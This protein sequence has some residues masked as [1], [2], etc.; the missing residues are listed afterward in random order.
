ME[1]LITNDDG[2]G[3]KGIMTLVRLM[4]TFG[5]VTVVAPGT[6]QSGKSNAITFDH[7]LLH[8]I[9]RTDKHVVYTTNGTP[10]DCVK[11]AIHIIYKGGKPDLLVSGINHGSNA[12]INVIYSGTMGAVFV[13]AENGIRSIGFSLDS[14]DPDADFSFMEPYIVQIVNEVLKDTLNFKLSNQAAT[15]NSKL[16]TLNSK[17][18]YGLCWNVNAPVGE[19]KGVRLTRQCQGYWD[20]EVA[21]IEDEEGGV[22]YKLGGQFCNTEPDAEDTDEWALHHGYIAITPSTVDTTHLIY[23]V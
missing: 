3:A 16:S 12:A 2:W 6:V 22:Y 14:Y 11:L 13:G 19:I 23:Y 7:L 10:S 9:E 21:T 17:D 20:E 15:L 4:E 8:E 5:H 1:I 18:K